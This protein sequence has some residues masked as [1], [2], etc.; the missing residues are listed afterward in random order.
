MT[1]SPLYLRLDEQDLQHALMAFVEDAGYPLDTGDLIEVT[2]E[3]AVSPGFADTGKG[4]FVYTY[5]AE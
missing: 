4:G 3:A 5:E 1:R 2:V